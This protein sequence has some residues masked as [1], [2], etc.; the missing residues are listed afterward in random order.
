[1]PSTTGSC[2]RARI[3]TLDAS[4]NVIADYDLVTSTPI[5]T[6][7]GFNAFE[8]RCVVDSTADIYGLC[9]GGDYI[10]LHQKVILLN[11]TFPGKTQRQRN[12]FRLSRP[13]V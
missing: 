9:F 7:G 11:D 6:P 3:S 13:V 8:F 4:G 2:A 10:L 5:S 12:G 1:M